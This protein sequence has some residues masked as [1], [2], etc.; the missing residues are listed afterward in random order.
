MS[1][2][3][4][5]LYGSTNLAGLIPSEVSCIPRFPLQ[6]ELSLRGAKGIQISSTS[7][8]YKN[9]Q[10]NLGIPLHQP[11]TL[12]DLIE[13]SPMARRNE[14]VLM[15]SGGIDCTAL[16]L[17]EAVGKNKNDF[18]PLFLIHL[19]ISDWLR[20]QTEEKL[21]KIAL[22][23]FQKRLIDNEMGIG[24]VSIPGSPEMI[25]DKKRAT[26]FFRNLYRKVPAWW[27]L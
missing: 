5:L 11:V 13:K 10:L 15:D 9:I 16:G 27:L 25:L 24:Y 26:I 8:I 1:T 19:D 7:I 4:T 12:G 14:W 21:K 23:A 18:V 3:P 17:F 2:L 22:A 20:Q 6:A